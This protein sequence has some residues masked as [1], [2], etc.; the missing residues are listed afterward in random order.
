MVVRLDDGA[1]GVLYPIVRLE[2]RNGLRVLAPDMQDE[3]PDLQ[4]VYSEMDS[5]AQQD[6]AWNPFLV[7]FYMPQYQREQFYEQQDR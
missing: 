7:D 2:E 1:D 4:F 3:E 5:F 6:R